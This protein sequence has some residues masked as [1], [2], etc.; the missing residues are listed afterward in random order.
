MTT[1][2]ILNATSFV[3]SQIRRDSY[4]ESILATCVIIYNDIISSAIELAYDENLIR[5]EFLKYLQ[6]VQ[7]KKNNELHHLKFDKETIEHKGRADIRVLPTMAEY[8]DDDE[9]YLIECKRLGYGNSHSTS[10]SELN[11]E[12]VKN[13]ICRF[14]SG[15]YSSHYDCN[16]MFGFLVS[17]VCVQTDII[18]D[19]NTKLN[20]DYINA[21]KRKVNANAKKQLTYENFANGY[22]YSYI[23][24]HTHAS[25]KDLVLYHLIFD[26]S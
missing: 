9:Y 24:T 2:S 17:Q 22:P 13:G 18:D 15:Y 12:Y 6:N 23:S 10:A 25:R 20:K 21:Q 14:V 1:C 8:I 19:I 5:D 4:F 11:T 26:F 7:F 3:Y 16:A